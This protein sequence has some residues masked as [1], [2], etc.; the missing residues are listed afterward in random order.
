MMEFYIWV[1]TPGYLH[2][3]KDLWVLLIVSVSH[4][5]LFF[6]NAEKN[7]LKRPYASQIS[8]CL[9]ELYLN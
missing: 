6:E 9:P 7:C 5:S 4:S 2:F 3:E 1:S 8:I